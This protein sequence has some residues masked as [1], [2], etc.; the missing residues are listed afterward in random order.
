MKNKLDKNFYL[1]K[2]IVLTN[3]EKKGN[4]I[5]FKYFLILE[6]EAAL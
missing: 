6:R 2:R 3:M 4:I 1:A 5:F